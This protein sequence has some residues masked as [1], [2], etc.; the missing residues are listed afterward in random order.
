[1]KTELPRFEGRKVQAA[2]LRLTGKTRDRVGALSLDEEVFLIVRGTVSQ[3]AH[4]D[5]VE[6]GA[7]AFTR[8]HTLKAS[9]IVLIEADQGAKML[10]EAV[11]MAGERFG[12]R[13]L[14]HQDPGEPET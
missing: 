9:D 11:M 10:D 1:M 8:V 2:T 13:D 4:T 6:G 5:V 3:I 7:D 12:V 14:F